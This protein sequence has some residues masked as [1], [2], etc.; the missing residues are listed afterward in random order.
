MG[1]FIVVIPSERLVV[2]RLAAS[3][4]RG[5]DIEETDRLI[6]A[7]RKVLGSADVAPR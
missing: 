5:D 2:V 3:P 4:V 1:Q 7:I 6:H